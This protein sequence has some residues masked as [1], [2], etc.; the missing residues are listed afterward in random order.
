MRRCLQTEAFIGEAQLDVLILSLKSDNKFA[1]S[2]TAVVTGF[3]LR[4]LYDQY[5]APVIC[6]VL[7]LLSNQFAAPVI[8]MVLR[9]LSNQCA[10]PVICQN[11]S[12]YANPLGI[13]KIIN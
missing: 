11:V 12:Y 4:L 7:R 5:A 13:N 1:F 8:G 3:C 6:M 2:V 10:A 9:L